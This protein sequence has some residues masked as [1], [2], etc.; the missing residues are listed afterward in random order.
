ML[1]ELNPL[2]I[3]SKYG[4]R[5]R[6]GV[7]EFHPGVDIRVVDKKYVVYPV[8]APEKMVISK[9]VFDKQWGHAI[10]A[11][12]GAINDLDVDEFRFW[13]IKP[14]EKC[15]PGATYDEDEK[16]GDPESGFVDLHLHFECRKGGKTIDPLKYF[17][18]RGQE[19]VIK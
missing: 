9:V 7:D 10:Y 13:H 16:I 8:L 4:P 11:R 1:F 17:V 15:V 12:T 18:M 2:T 14:T 19:F 6:N 5:T 3:V